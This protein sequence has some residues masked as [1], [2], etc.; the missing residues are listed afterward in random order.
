MNI[1]RKEPLNSL[2]Y[3]FIEKQYIPKGKDEYYLRNRQNR[4]D[5]IYRALSRTAIRILEKNG[6]SSDNWNMVMVAEA[7]DPSLVKNCKFYGLV[8]IGKLEPYFHE[9]NNL[10]LPVGLYNSTIISS[11]I[12]DNAVIDNVGFMSHYITGNDVM[13]VNINEL[14]TTD[15]AKFGNGVL[16]QGEQE[17][18]RIWLEICNENA[19]RSILPY[20]GMQVADAYLWSKHRDDEKLLQ[21]FREFTDAKYDTRR[22]YYGKIGDRT[23]IKNCRIIKDT[24]IGTDAY[25]KGA[26]KIKNIT[27][28]SSPAAK[29]QIG[30]GCELVNGIIGFGCRIFYGVKAVRFVMGSNS[31]LKYGARLI[32]SFLGDN[33][34]I[35]CCE[36]LNSLIFPAHEQ[37]HNNSFL[38]AATVFGQSNMAAGA[39]IGSNHNSRG[40]DGE[41]IAGRGFWPGLCV[42]LKHNSKFASFTLIA[43]GDFPAELNIPIPFSLLSNDVSNER[44]LL[45]PAYWFMYN[46]YALA[47]NVTKYTSRDKRTDQ[48]IRIEY[49]YLAPD[50]VNEIFDGLQ[51]LR[52]FTGAAWARKNNQV[53]NEKACIQKGKELLDTKPN[54]AA[55]LE[56]LANGFENSRRKVVILKAADA[57]TIFQ[58]LIVYYGVL[59]I[60]RL[61]ERKKLTSWTALQ[62]ALPAS[63]AR[64][65]WINCGGL[66]MKES[67]VQTLLSNI[68]SGKCS[69]WDEVHEYYFRKSHG[70]ETDKCSHALASLLEILSLSPSRFTK[71]TFLQLL[72]KVLRIR[73]WITEG[74]SESRA[75]DYQSPFRKMVYD[76]REEM[77][78]VMGKLSDNSFIREQQKELLA[79]REKINNLQ[80]QFS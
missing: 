8:R 11:D 57:S 47:R 1:I 53:L 26:N 49:D 69:N 55:T 56:I 22:G 23:V 14:A 20:N 68:R 35:S 73:E 21:R 65:K 59:E 39:T 79:F 29:T 41:L 37:H 61:I 27:I 78:K 52:Q 75:R 19:G 44:L 54:E 25:L 28:N 63:P 5:T 36:V 66:L 71:K 72:P 3:G 58:E 67:A 45:M 42:S 31:Q 9:F 2:G 17:N 7:F 12:G 62:K 80:T 33:S 60:I 10:R 6:N 76:T 51:L 77:E 34:T 46:M 18:I 50:S 40:A 13:L 48:R 4:N 16:K 38:C 70:Y 30:E 64:S 32:N 24:W 43:K 15:H 74:I